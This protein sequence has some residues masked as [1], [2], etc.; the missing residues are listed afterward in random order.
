MTK[1]LWNTTKEENEQIEKAVI[2][3]R[4]KHPELDA[5][6]LTMDLTACH[7][8]GSP[9]DFEKL[10]SFDDFNFFHDVMGIAYLMDR[11]TGKLMNCFSPR[12]SKKQEQNYDRSE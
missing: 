12:A 5:L 7:L 4:E 6:T 10:L 9:I 8:N 1:I 2:R 11:R 3:A